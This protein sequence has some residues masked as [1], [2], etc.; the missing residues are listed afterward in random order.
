MNKYPEIILA[1]LIIICAW[2]SI[3]LGADVLTV[4]WDA[5]KTDTD[6]NVCTDLAGYKVYANDSPAVDVG[7]VQ[8][9]TQ[10]VTDCRLWC[11]EVTAYDT[12]GN[13]GPRSEKL[14]KAV[15][16]SPINLRQ[17]IDIV[18]DPLSPEEREK[19]KSQHS[20]RGEAP[21]RNTQDG[22]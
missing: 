2:A 14:C 5:P 20:R 12:S 16:T 4:S 6:G 9:Y 18:R 21:G 8:I 7:N 17:E 1:V 3:T 22:V 10:E 15:L 11:F 19:K 13:E